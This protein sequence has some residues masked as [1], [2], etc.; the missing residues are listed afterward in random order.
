MLQL[1]LISSG[2]FIPHCSLTVCPQTPEIRRER[3]FIEA[4]S[5]LA[6]FKLLNSAGQPMMPIEIRLT[7]DKLS[8]ISRLLSSS[9]D[10]YRHPEMVL[11]IVAKLGYRGDQLAEARVLAMLADAALQNNGGD[12]KRAADICERMLRVVE[13]IRRGR[14]KERA[15]KAAEMAWKTCYQ[16]GRSASNGIG[17][18]F[19]TT[20]RSNSASSREAE[21]AHSKQKELLGHALL[22]CP[23]DQIHEVLTAWRKV[24]TL[25]TRGHPNPHKA[26]QQQQHTFD[27]SR[28]LGDRW[29]VARKSGYTQAMRSADSPA[30]STG[31]ALTHSA[32]SAARAAINVGRAA[33]AYLPFNR[34]STPDSVN[35]SASS[36][37]SP[38]SSSQGYHSSHNAH[39][40]D[41]H[42]SQANQGHTR[43]RSESRN[44]IRGADVVRDE[45]SN[46]SRA[47]VSWL[48]GAD[49]DE[50]R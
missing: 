46:K 48:I 40:H 20:D 42:H 26:A 4:T 43:D 18:S 21:V 41:R 12:I 3:E 35:F 27:S 8:L 34:T 1:K 44:S 22:L 16:F 10:L 30:T 5:R 19:A 15:D 39:Q 37:A 28:A 29:Y 7:E 14:D 9:D 24:E 38:S 47:L 13:Q 23:A 45:L 50:R 36:N 11:D 6:S 17:D 32:E 49:E 33:S 25:Q 31:I 2:F